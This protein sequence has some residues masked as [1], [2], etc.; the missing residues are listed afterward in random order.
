MIATRLTHFLG[1]QYPILQA[2]MGG[3][4]RA[5][6][7]AAV[8]VAGG[9]GVLGMIRMRPDFIR[10]QIRRVREL[11]DRPFGINLVP[12]VV[13]PEEFEAQVAVCLEERVPVLSLAWAEPAPRLIE[14]AHAEGI[15]LLQQVGDVAE[16]EQAVEAGVDVIVAQG[17]EAGGHLMGEVGVLA[18]V[19]RIVDAVAPTP[20]VAAGGIVDG[21]GVVAALALGAEGVWVGTRFIASEESEAHPTYKQRLL[22]AGDGDTLRTDRFSVG[23]PSGMPH[24]VLRTPTAEGRYQPGGPVARARIGERVVEVPAFSSAPPTI[25]TEGEIE[26][27]PLYAGQSVGAIRAIRPAGEIVRELVDEAE[28]IIRTRLAHILEG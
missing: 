11:T 21:R 6:L 22:A 3:V 12:A 26:A 7:A 23:W 8:S 20:V 17:A 1:I 10:A 24:R 9:L 4:A 14:R 25:H 16:A 28:R 13:S 27:M 18:L 5:G 15:L 2:G 19:P